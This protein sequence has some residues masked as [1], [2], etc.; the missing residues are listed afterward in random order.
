MP[1]PT[2][3]REVAQ[4]RDKIFEDLRVAS[5][6]RKGVREISSRCSENG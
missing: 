3:P 6:L 2:D 1:H 5:H 4:L